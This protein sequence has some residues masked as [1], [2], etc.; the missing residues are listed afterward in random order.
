MHKEGLPISQ[1]ARI[2][3]RSEEEV[4]ALIKKEDAKK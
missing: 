2:A 1:I 3:R 4:E